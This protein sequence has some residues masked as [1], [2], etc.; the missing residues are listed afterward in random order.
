M[1]VLITLSKA[2]A[3]FCLCLAVLPYS[4][5]HGIAS[6][7][8]ISYESPAAQTIE[9]VAPPP[10]PTPPVR[11]CHRSHPSHYKEA[12]VNEPVTPPP[13]PANPEETSGCKHQ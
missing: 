8:T 13:P 10:A 6:A 1:P 2:L 7:A 12:H 5:H 9:T 11:H 3:A 4:V